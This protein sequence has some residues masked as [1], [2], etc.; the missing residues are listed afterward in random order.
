MKHLSASVQ[1][2]VFRISAAYTLRNMAEQLERQS[3]YDDEIAHGLVSVARWY[4]ENDPDC[5]D[6]DEVQ[7]ELMDALRAQPDGLTDELPHE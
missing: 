4:A 7:L 3:G 6:A 5:R 2:V 1:A